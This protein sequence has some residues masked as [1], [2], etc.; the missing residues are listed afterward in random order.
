MDSVRLGLYLGLTS[1]ILFPLWRKARKHKANHPPSPPSLP[2][3]GNLFSIPPEH[4][5]FAFLKLGEQLESDIIYLEILGQKIIVL[6]SAEA[7]SDLLSKRSA[8]YSDRPVIPMVT[9]PDLMNWSGNVSIVRYNDVWRLYRRIMNDWLNARAVAQFCILQERQTR[10]LLCELL[11]VTNHTQPFEPVKNAFF[12]AMGSSMLEFAYG[13]K[14]ENAQDI[15]LEES[16]L[17]FHNVL[18]ASMQT[19]FL[20]NV[21]PVLSYIPEWFPGAGWKR[22]AREWGLQQDK[23]KTEPYEWLK[24]QVASGTHQLSLLGPLIKD[25]KLLSDLT[26][27]DRDERLKE[28]GIILFGGGTD[29]SA[30]FLIGFVLAMVLNPHIQENAQHELDTIVGRAVLP[31]VSDKEPLLY[32]MNLI[33]EVL[34]LYPTL[35]LALPHTCYQDDTYRGYNIEKGTTIIGNLWA[36]GR[37]PRHYKDPEVFNPDRYLDPNVPRPPVFGWGRRKCP[38]VHFAENITFVAT[39]SLL[40][41][42][43]FSRKKDNNLQEII[44]QVELERNS[45]ILELKPFEFELKSRS[46][47]H[48]QVLPG[49]IDE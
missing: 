14:P 22:T 46:N 6:N 1:L 49:I 29:T 4:E 24:A 33:D 45:L 43:N 27:T 30:S 3:V 38:G 26:P 5:H 19:S 10:S 11:R 32:V 7:A 44:P 18:L 13:Y 39:A 34:R 42:L 20:V 12:F 2:F 21:F 37:D 17:A 47:E 8:L 40:A 41:F 15:F 31:S 23:A 28:I 35:S 9:N 16:Q 25:H 48:Q 36:M